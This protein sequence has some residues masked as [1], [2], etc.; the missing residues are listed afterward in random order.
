MGK[1]NLAGMRPV[2][3]ADQPGVADGVMRRAK[4]TVANQ[5]EFLNYRI[6]SCMDI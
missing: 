4:G 1:R 2:A 3:A 6:I 5:R